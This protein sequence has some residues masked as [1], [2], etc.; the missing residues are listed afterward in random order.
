MGDLFARA[1]E[2]EDAIVNY[3]LAGSADKARTLAASIERVVP[4]DLR[5]LRGRPH[6]LGT[7]I[8]V[9]GAQ[10]DFIPEATVR[11]VVPELLQLAHGVRQAA[12]SPTVNKEALDALGE[13]SPMFSK[14]EAAACLDLLAPAIPRP[15]TTATF[16]DSAIQAVLPT[17]WEHHRRLRNRVERM[18]LEALSQPDLAPQLIPG[19]TWIAERSPSLA[20]ALRRLAMSGNNSAAVALGLAKVDC[21]EATAEARRQAAAVLGR[22]GLDGK[23]LSFG[24]GA[25]LYLAGQLGSSIRPQERDELAQKYL[26]LA[27]NRYEA[28]PNRTSAVLGLRYL[29]P[30]LPRRRQDQLFAGLLELALDKPS[31]DSAFDELVRESQHPLSRFR[32]TFGVSSLMKSSL[33]GA[34]E[35]ANSDAHARKL[36]PLLGQA[37]TSPDP[38]VVTTA[39]ASVGSIR[40]EV[41]PAVDWLSWATHENAKIRAAVA[42]LWTR[43]TGAPAR[44]GIALAGDPARDVRFAIA[45]AGVDGRRFGSRQEYLRARRMLSRDVSA[46]VRTAA[47]RWA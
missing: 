35:L 38:G 47:L 18:V 40:E 43:S 17:V 20:R 5:R 8:A 42:I 27:E 1:G 39:L 44:L 41:R 23:T 28:E 13:L 2:T 34:A 31:T 30:L 25:H 22:Q 12:T 6:R 9:I 46:M 36:E 4:T 14:P 3:V 37:L 21:P 7:A 24:F 45:A 15:P 26:Q 11:Q 32:L 19:T 16:S 10:A 33:R 29:A